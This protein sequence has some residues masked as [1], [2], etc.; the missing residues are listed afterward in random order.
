MR[1]AFRCSP[2]DLGHTVG[3]AGTQKCIQA[4]GSEVTVRDPG[5][6][7]WGEVFDHLV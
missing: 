5:D 2:E 7:L 3:Y 1:E 6:K 4:D